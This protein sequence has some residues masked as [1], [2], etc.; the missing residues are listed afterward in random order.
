MYNVTA[1]YGCCSNASRSS[2]PGSVRVNLA[3]SSRSISAAQLSADGERCAAA[4]KLPPINRK[5]VKSEKISRRFASRGFSVPTLLHE[6]HASVVSTCI[7][8]L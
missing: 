8:L 7:D 2:G 3:S 4:V 6:Q 1:D 5:S